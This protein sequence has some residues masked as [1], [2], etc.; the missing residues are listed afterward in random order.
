MADDFV[1]MA[2]R[3]L[4]MVKAVVGE[5]QLEVGIVLPGRA[6]FLI[7][8]AMAEPTLVRLAQMFRRLNPVRIGFA[9]CRWS[10]ARR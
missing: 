10:G 2:D 5:R 8:A 1:T 3:E 4:D 7:V 9:A 6:Q